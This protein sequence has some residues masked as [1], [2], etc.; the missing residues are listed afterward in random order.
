MLRQPQ[1][2]LLCAGYVKILS[3]PASEHLGQYRK[4]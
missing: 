4:S 2:T 3:V 1:C